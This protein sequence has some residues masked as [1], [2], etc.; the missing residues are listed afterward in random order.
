MEKYSLWQKMMIVAFGTF[1]IVASAYATSSEGSNAT[2]LLTNTIPAMTGLLAAPDPVKGGD[3]VV[4]SVSVPNDNDSDSLILDCHTATGASQLNHAFC[5]SVSSSYPYST[6]NCSG[7]SVHDDSEHEVFCVLYDGSGYSAEKSVNYTSDSTPPS[8]SGVLNSPA[9]PQDVSTNIM[10][11]ATVTDASNVSTVYLEWNGVNYTVTDYKYISA[12]TREYYTTVTETGSGYYHHKWYANDTAGNIGLSEPSGISFSD[13]TLGTHSG[14]E[15]SGGVLWNNGTSIDASYTSPVQDLNSALQGASFEWENLTY[16]VTGSSTWVFVEMRSSS[17]GVIWNSWVP[18]HNATVITITPQRYFQYKVWLA[19][20][21]A[22]NVSYANFDYT[23]TFTF[24]GPLTGGSCAIDVSDGNS[25]TA[26]YNPASGNYSTDIDVNCSDPYERTLTYNVT[27]SKAGYDTVHY[28]NRQFYVDTCAPN[29]TGFAITP[30]QLFTKVNDVFTDTDLT[31]SGNIDDVLLNQVYFAYLTPTNLNWLP[32]YYNGN[33]SIGAYSETFNLYAPS[34][35]YNIT[36]N[37]RDSSLRT[38][39]QWLS[40]NTS[41]LTITNGIPIEMQVFSIDNPG[42]ETRLNV[43]YRAPVVFIEDGS[44]NLTYDWAFPIADTITNVTNIT[45]STGLSLN[46]LTYNG[47]HIRFTS[48]YLN[49]SMSDTLYWTVEN[50]LYYKKLSAFGGNPKVDAFMI[51]TSGID[52][53]SLARVTGVK[54]N[55]TLTTPYDTAAAH[56]EILYCGTFNYNAATCT[57]TLPYT[58]TFDEYDTN[59][60]G[61]IDKVGFTMPHLSDE[62][63]IVEVETGGGCPSG[64]YFCPASGACIVTGAI[65]GGGGG[66]GGGGEEGAARNFWYELYQGTK[67]IASGGAS[68]SMTVRADLAPTEYASF[69]FRVK[70]Q[71]NNLATVQVLSPSNWMTIT[72]AVSKEVGAMSSSDWEII[73]QG[74]FAGTKSGDIVVNIDGIGAKTVKVQM[75]GNM[76]AEQASVTGLLGLG[77]FDD[78]LGKS[79]DIFG[80]K[81]PMAFLVFVALFAIALGIYQT[82][83]KQRN[84]AFVLGIIAV[85]ILLIY[86]DLII[87]SLMNTC[88]VVA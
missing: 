37:A 64:T 74:D 10:F 51:K 21:T 38:T 33:P 59:G 75:Q 30:T 42:A 31:I 27:C 87:C 39:A 8:F 72:P 18:Q 9:S 34:G 4:I 85:A 70:N 7:T 49:S 19:G 80:I 26:T 25:Y 17:D 35:E 23:K 12:S 65:C 29:A 62:G 88:V 66:G 77:F 20:S 3:G 83:P 56:A 86:N 79:I 48:E 58:Y 22:A 44:A 57:G 55:V 84:Y 61:L 32:F 16:Y 47:T 54:V 63:I 68:D 53:S 76:T 41:E 71:E 6:L 11:N 1:L 46:N 36:I 45:S 67:L 60:D 82:Y 40:V 81:L 69:T 28:Y 2:A 50:G 78:F 24:N 43:S 52:E 73:L 14:T 13:F 5:Q 15:F